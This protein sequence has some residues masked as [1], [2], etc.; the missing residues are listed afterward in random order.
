MCASPADTPPDGGAKTASQRASIT[1]DPENMLLL[2]TEVS[3]SCQSV[4][5]VYPD[6]IALPVYSLDGKYL[7]AQVANADGKI[8]ARRVLRLMW[9]EQHQAPVVYVEREYKNPGVSPESTAQM[10]ELIR[11]LAQKMGV[12][13]ATD[14]KALASSE[15]VGLLS[16][17]KNGQPFDYVDAGHAVGKIEPGADYEMRGAYVMRGA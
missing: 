2:G 11:A 5:G 10:L 6:K 17:G 15:P 16:A 13:V 1:C 12:Q 9:S 7:S 3:N 8:M 14:D 4:D